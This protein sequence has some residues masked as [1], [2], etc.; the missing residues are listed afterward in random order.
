MEVSDRQY[1]MSD[2]WYFPDSFN[3]KKEEISDNNMGGG[4]VTIKAGKW[5]EFISIRYEQVLT[6]NIMMS[7]IFIINIKI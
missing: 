1:S 7:I 2:I 4:S 6:L 3:G 5:E